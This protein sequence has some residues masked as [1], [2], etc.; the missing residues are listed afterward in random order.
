MRTAAVVSSD[1][2][3]EERKVESPQSWD[4]WNICSAHLRI[5]LPV[6][7]AY[8]L[9]GGLKSKEMSVSGVGINVLACFRMCP[10]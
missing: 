9:P 4:D 2:V 5:A 8:G 6:S 7:V 3:V 10:M 1:G